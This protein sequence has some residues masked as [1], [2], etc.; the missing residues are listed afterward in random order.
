[1]RGGRGK[2]EELEDLGGGFV[3]ADKQDADGDCGSFH[4]EDCGLRH[5]E[6]AGQQEADCYQRSG[7]RLVQAVNGNHGECDEDEVKVA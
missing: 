6:A 7:D 2:A 1:M 4:A 3:V 5:G